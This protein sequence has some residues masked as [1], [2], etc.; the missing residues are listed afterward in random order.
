MRGCGGL[1]PLAASDCLDICRKWWAR[2]RRNAIVACSDG[3]I[4]IDRTHLGLDARTGAYIGVSES[5]DRR[6]CLFYRGHHLTLFASFS[7]S[8]THF[9]F[10]NELRAGCLPLAHPLG[11]CGSPVVKQ[12]FFLCYPVII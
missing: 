11:I 8:A 7:S 4:V 2:R 10:R 3:Q 5:P 6:W 9:Y 1:G 12:L